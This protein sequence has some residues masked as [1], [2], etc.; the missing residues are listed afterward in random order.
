MRNLLFFSCESVI[1]EGGLVVVFSSGGKRSQD[2]LIQENH[3]FERSVRDSLPIF[4]RGSA[5][6]SWHA[7]AILLDSSL[8]VSVGL[9][10]HVY[11]R[12]GTDGG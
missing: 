7:S 6:M 5:E 11:I 3:F 2:S 1:G 8:N 12:L 9:E 10:F 4:F